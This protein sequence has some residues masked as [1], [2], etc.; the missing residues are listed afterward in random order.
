MSDVEELVGAEIRR[1]A[2]RPQPAEVADM[3]RRVRHARR[4]AGMVTASV[5]ALLVVLAS[6]AVVAALRRDPT[7]APPADTYPSGLTVTRPTDAYF[8]DADHGFALACRC[9]EQ[10]R[11][12]W[13]ASTS[14]GGQS[15]Q[16]RQVPGQDWHDRLEL[17]VFD[18]NRVAITSIDRGSGSDRVWFTP[19][20][21]HTWHPRSSIPEGRVAQ[22]PLLAQAALRPSGSRPFDVIVYRPDGTSALLENVPGQL[23]GSENRN[24]RAA[25]DG[26]LWISGNATIHVSR[27]RGR[28]WAQV[29]TPQYEG[30]PLELETIDGRHVYVVDRFGPNG[31]RIWRLGDGGTYWEHL[32]LPLTPADSTA[33]VSYATPDGG[34]MIGD[35]RNGVEYRLAPGARSFDPARPGLAHGFLGGRYWRSADDPHEGNPPYHHSADGQQW[36]ELRL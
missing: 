4:R 30:S 10:A 20:R 23:A 35:F 32:R 22:V 7:P 3:V 36:T 9:V 28:T 15:W 13:L 12:T 16:A 34:L 26:S 6:T 19:D 5:A 31:Y 1:L 2:G 24:V 29:P 27:D 11:E 14:D 25:T 18:R 21:G 17:R 8:I 33:V